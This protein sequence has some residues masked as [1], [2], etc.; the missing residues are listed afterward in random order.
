MINVRTQIGLAIALFGSLAGGIHAQTTAPSGALAPSVP[1]NPQPTTSPG[2]PA[3]AAGLSQAPS[4]SSSINPANRPVTS[5]A[6]TV[7]LSPED[8]AASRRDAQTPITL[9]EAIH[10]AQR[11]DHAYVSAIADKGS[12]DATRTVARSALLPNVDYH[13]QALYTQPQRPY[14]TTNTSTRDGGPTPIFIANN[15]V[16]EY[17]SQGVV[18]ET[19]G[20][21]RVADLRRADADAAAAK[22]RLEIARRGLV[23]TVVAGYYAVLS[24]DEKARVAARALDEANK[25]LKLSGQLEMGGEVAHAD[26]IKA[27]LQQ[28][29]RERDSQDAQLAAEKARLDL[30]VLL[31]PDPTVDYMLVLD[32]NHPPALATREELEVVAKTSNPDVRAALANLKAAKFG[33]SSSIGAYLP[34]LSLAYNYGIDSDHFAIH[35]AN[36][37]RNLGYAVSGALDIPVWD[38]FATRARVKESQL[39]RDLAKADLTATQRKTLAAFE[40][41]YHEADVAS[42]QI[43]SL[44]RS[45]AD[46]REALRLT[47]LRYSS[48]EG[49]VLEVVD[50]QTTVVTAETSRADGVVRYYTALASLQTMT[51]NMP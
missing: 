27:R 34:E 12:A 40:E 36:G 1:A 19:V 6:D 3:P 28:S 51:G 39:V 38:W 5:I 46:A 15:S 32:L 20:Y 4:M 31:F 33:V 8:E 48:G 18:T 14:V 35:D 22:A 16:R 47:T 9:E 49:S 17:I 45:V 7:T 37:I 21:G 13:N 11:I 10:R 42:Q 29:Q 25:F 26:V 43:A 41:I 44:D 23:S 30:G 50:A 24:S 2:T